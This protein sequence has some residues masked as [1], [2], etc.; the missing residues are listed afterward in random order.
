MDNFVS[1][2]LFFLFIELMVF[3]ILMGTGKL[4]FWVEKKNKKGGEKK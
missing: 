3:C 2:I 1:G 4:S